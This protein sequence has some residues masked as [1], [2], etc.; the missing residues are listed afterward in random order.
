MNSVD[1]HKIYADFDI[2]SYHITLENKLFSFKCFWA[3]VV[4]GEEGSLLTQY[5]KHSFYELQ[6]VLRGSMEMN[7][8][9]QEKLYLNKSDFTIIPPE[10]YHQITEADEAGDRCIMAF[11][12]DTKDPQFKKQLSCLSD[13]KIYSESHNMRSLFSMIVDKKD[14]FR[15]PIRKEALLSLMEAFVLEMLEV[16]TPKNSE[17]PEQHHGASYTD[18]LIR[19]IET[20]IDQC[21]GLSVSVAELS[22]KFGMCE[23]HLNR[24]FQQKR[25]YTL[26]TAIN[27]VK[28]KTIEEMIASTNFTLCEISE[29]CGFSD[30]YGMNKFFRRINK[31][32]LSDFKKIAKKN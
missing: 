29:L 14:S 6:Y 9:N 19:K 12:L 31:I 18:N 1:L 21:K 23:R 32:N 20:Y 25:G 7:I 3:R 10:T 11:S 22:K 24:L 26:K 28:I 4:S 5:T 17:L 2:G 15:N 30:E 27:R 8:G 13:I 16:I